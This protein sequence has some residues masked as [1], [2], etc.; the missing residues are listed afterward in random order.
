MWD[1]VR[2]DCSQQWLATADPPLFIESTLCAKKCSFSCV[3]WLSLIIPFWRP[4]LKWQC[5]HEHM[6]NLTNIGASN[7]VG[8]FCLVPNSNRSSMN[9]NYTSHVTYEKSQQ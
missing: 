1:L 6:C 2:T 5:K 8:Y 9:P 4:L 7:T 3:S